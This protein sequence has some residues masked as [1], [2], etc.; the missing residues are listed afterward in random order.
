MISKKNLLLTTTASLLLPIGAPANDIEPG[1]EF[2]TA[3]KI[4]TPIILDGDLSEWAGSNVLADPRFSIPKGSGSDPNVVGELVNFELHGGDWT[5]PD[6]HTSSV[7]VV[8]DD[9]NVYFGF[10]VTD[11]Y[12][13]HASAPAWKGDAVQLMVANDARDTQ[14]A[15]YNYALLGIENALGDIKIQH[16]A[17][18]GGTEAV[19]TRNAVTKKTIYEIKLPKSALELSSLTEGVQ[20]GLGMAIND[21]D[22]LTPNQSGWGGLGA[23]SIVFGKSPEETALITLGSNVPNDDAAFL[24]AIGS[25]FTT[26]SFRA[27]DVGSSVI[28]PAS[29]TLTIDGAPATLVASTVEAGV[30]DFTHTF[31]EPFPSG[32]VLPFT[33]EVSDT[34]GAIISETSTFTTA[35]FATLTPEMRASNIATNKPGFIWRVFQNEADVHNSLSGAELALTGNGAAGTQNNAS[36]VEPFGPAIG[37]PIVVGPAMLLEFE[38]PTVINLNSVGGET[39]GNF[40]P[41]DQ[42]P[43]V[44]GSNSSNG[45]NAEIISYVQFPSGFTTMGVNSDDG[46]RAQSGLINDPENRILL[47]E[48][49]AS[50]GTAETLFLI[51]VLEAGIYPLRAI[52]ENGNGSAHIEIFTIKDDGSKVLLNDMAN[53]GL[54]TF[55]SE[56]GAPFII[57]STTRDAAGNLTIIWNSTPGVSYA[58]DFATSLNSEEDWNEFDDGL[59]TQGTSSQV[60]VNAATVSANT[61]SNRIFFRIREL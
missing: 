41:D 45:A 51:N 6:D 52:W 36:S 10:T 1:K 38:I 12:H 11:E 44:P 8:Y 54:Q 26:F 2:Y 37:A 20:F 33:I 31:S 7:Q 18:P 13:E 21:G 35:T 57:T 48:F 16:E 47:G 56:I 43:G 29:A 28:D 27:N 5:G 24:A 34:N 30:T 14:I 23:H 42:M 40:G 32:A 9:D 55:R 46:F 19:V 17:G 58:L 4:V 59:V 49:G 60:K 15:L 3:L 22:E 53:G 61:S 39:A 50:R 25:N